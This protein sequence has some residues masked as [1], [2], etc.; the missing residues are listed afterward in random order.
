MKKSDFIFFLL[1]VLMIFLSKSNSIPFRIIC[2]AV[3]LL[4]TIDIIKTL[5][6][7]KHGNREA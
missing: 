7:A 4:L 2:G 3:S 1:P 5:R 6:S